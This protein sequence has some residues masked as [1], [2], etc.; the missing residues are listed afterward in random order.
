M[1]DADGDG[2]PDDHDVCPNTFAPDGGDPLRE[3][4]IE[5]EDPY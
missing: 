5:G 2:V 3:G 4:C 1:P